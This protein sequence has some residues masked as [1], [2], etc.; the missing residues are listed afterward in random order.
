VLHAGPRV[1]GLRRP[2]P[3]GRRCSGGVTNGFQV[4]EVLAGVLLPGVFE[5][6]EHGGGDEG[7]TA[8]QAV[9]L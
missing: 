9:G 3:A 8:W 5:T 4:G 6:R 7:D 2:P 1:G